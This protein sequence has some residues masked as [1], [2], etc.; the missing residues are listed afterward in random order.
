IMALVAWQGRMP[1][2]AKTLRVASAGIVTF[3]VSGRRSKNRSC[4]SAVCESAGGMREFLA[5][6]SWSRHPKLGLLPGWI[7][8]ALHFNLLVGVGNKKVTGNTHLLPR[9]S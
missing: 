8:Q 1:V 3:G 7:F 9:L 4:G 5:W 6:R 2:R